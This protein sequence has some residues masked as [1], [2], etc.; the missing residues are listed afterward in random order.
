MNPGPETRGGRRLG[1]HHPVLTGFRPAR[2]REIRSPS[3]SGAMFR[4]NRSAGQRA[5]ERFRRPRPLVRPPRRRANRRELP[6]QRA[7][8]LRQI[9]DILRMVAEASGVRQLP[10][11]HRAARKVAPRDENDRNPPVRR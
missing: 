2:W 9:Y 3:I 4:M 5:L 1:R 7:V 6:E 10:G 11:E 8:H